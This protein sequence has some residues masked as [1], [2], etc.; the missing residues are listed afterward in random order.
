MSGKRST[1]HRRRSMPAGGRLSSSARR[2]RASSRVRTPTS[3]MPS[4]RRR[5]GCGRAGCS[6]R[7]P[8]ARPRGCAGRPGPTPRTSPA[9][10]DLAEE[11]GARGQRAVAERRGHRG[12]HAQ[13]GRRLRH[14]EAAGH[15]HEDVVAQQLEAHALLEHGQQQGG[16]VGVD[17]DAT[18]AAACRTT[19]GET[20]AC[21]STSIG[22]EPSSVAT[23]A[24]PGEPSTPLGQEQRGGIGHRLQARRPSSRR[25]PSRRPRRSG[26]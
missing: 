17:A 9:R 8:S 15:A 26:S 3:S 7:S 1:R 22:R 6:G 16:A 19:V 18:S 20:S 14:L 25:R 2:S 24:E 13:V 23:T 5:A 4:V 10:P 21:T 11:H 12:G